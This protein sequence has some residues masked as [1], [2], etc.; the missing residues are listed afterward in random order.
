[1][2]SG[3]HIDITAVAKLLRSEVD[4]SERIPNHFL[5][6]LSDR[7]VERLIRRL[8]NELGILHV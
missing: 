6:R 4:A 1:L 3:S 7:E 8:S 2:M 5:D